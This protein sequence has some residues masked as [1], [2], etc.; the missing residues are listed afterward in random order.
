MA[1]PSLPY[2]TGTRA[3]K[4]RPSSVVRVYERKDVEG[5]IF[6]TRAWVRTP[7]GRPEEEPLP[8]G[9]TVEEAVAIAD[10]AKARREREIQTGRHWAGEGRR[11]EPVTVATLFEKYRESE[12]AA[13][14][15]DKHRGDVIRSLRFWEARMGEKNV[16]E[17]N[18]A[19]VEKVAGREGRRRELSPRWVEKRLKHI[20]AAVRWGKRKARLYDRDPLD[21]IDYPDYEP[22]TDHLIYSEAATRTLWTPHEDVDWRVTLLVNVA[23]DTGRRIG[24]ML[25]L[26]V[27]DVVTDG[28]RIFLHFRKE[29][30]KGK[31]GA[32]VPVS[33]GTAELLADALER[34]EVED[35][36][37]LFPEG[38]LGYDDA[39]NQPW[40]VSAAIHAL[41]D[42]EEVLGIDYVEGR[43]YHGL[44]RRHIT[45]G[46]EVARGDTALVGDQ[47]GNVSAELIRKVYRK[48]N[49]RRMTT[50]VDAVREALSEDDE[51]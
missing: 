24:A 28:D 26:A 40:G 32:M 14:W 48:A 2:S 37:W 49:R 27:Q 44:K 33:F 17:L 3:S 29:F 30:D 41:H 23:A 38:R 10:L 15:S 34:D 20:R 16:L 22:E 31:R 47:T 1:Q 8:L 5:R 12:D 39:R 18:P 35:S 45:T 13:G 11:F 19:E 50:H 6:L 43:A 51:N 46:M 4:N 21:G 36:G 7:S 9:T 42:A 25:A